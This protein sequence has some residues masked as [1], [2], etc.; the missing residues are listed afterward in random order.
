M[1]GFLV[2][3]L[4]A[5]SLLAVIDTLYYYVNRRR[6]MGPFT[7]VCVE[8][9]AIIIEPAIFMGIEGDAIN[10]CCSESA[11]FSPAH[12]LSIYALIILAGAS[13]FFSSWRTRLSSPLFELVV[14]C[15]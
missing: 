4:A 1:L 3:L 12:R 8:I 2:L 5:V 14:N 10:D 13:Y 11:F 7:L 6:M 9:I 15:F